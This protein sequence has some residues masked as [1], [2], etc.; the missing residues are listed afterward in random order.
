MAKSEKKS[1]RQRK[2]FEVP[3]DL[4]YRTQKV[5]GSI[6]VED[7]EVYLCPTLAT[8]FLINMVLRQTVDSFNIL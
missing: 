5:T 7:L 8:S 6:P 1:V 3:G 2:N 4:L